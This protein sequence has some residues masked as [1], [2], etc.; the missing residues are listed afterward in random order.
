MVKFENP[1]NHEVHPKL[2][3]F[4]EAYKKKALFNSVL[5]AK[6]KLRT[7]PLATKIKILDSRVDP[8][9]EVGTLGLYGDSFIVGSERIEN[10]KYSRHNPDY[11]TKVSADM[12]RAVRTAV[13]YLCPATWD[14]ISSS[15]SDEA[16]NAY[17]NWVRAP[18]RAILEAINRHL[19]TEVI[20]KELL[21]A[22]NNDTPSPT[23]FV[24]PE[25]LNAKK[26]MQEN[27]EEEARRQALK[28]TPVFVTVDE[29]GRY[30]AVIRGHSYKTIE[31]HELPE[32]IGSKIG[33]LK[34]VNVEENAQTHI[35]EVGIRARGNCFWVYVTET[36]LKELKNEV[37]A[38]N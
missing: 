28:L 35:P 6:P 13:E 33:L 18:Q 14:M 11:R 3:E 27:M 21:N 24:T 30:V 29:H 31:Q 38:T 32:E 8:P 25:F 5:V 2:M 7:G 9:F 1:E 23:T 36:L 26:T 22:I 20:R 10:E 4:F 37:E 19:T 16:Q 17:N 34:M 12:R 15:S